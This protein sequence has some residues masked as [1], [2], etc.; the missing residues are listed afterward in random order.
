METNT[1][2]NVNVNT[3][4][5]NTDPTT[6][7]DTTTQ[8]EKLYTQ[9][10]LDSQISKLFTK[11]ENK[12]NKQQSQ[13]EKLKGLND[14]QRKY[15]EMEMKLQEYEERLKES[16]LDKN[17][18]SAMQ[19]LAERNLPT[20]FVDYIVCEDAE[21]MLSRINTFDKQFKSA[22]NDA[23]S[24]KIGGNAPKSSS[25]TQTGMT[26]D[27]FR[28]LSISEMN[29]LYTSNPTLYKQLSQR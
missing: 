29:E 23:V 19:V 20:S 2:T 6:N 12:F 17:K 5:T 4:T 3:D 22:V 27:D 28:K 10:D 11:W 13:A 24:K 21:E 8:N 26:R 25:S 16:T 9:A 1:N 15:A 7:T 14:E 18:A